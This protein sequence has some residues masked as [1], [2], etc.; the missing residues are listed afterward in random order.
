LDALATTKKCIHLYSLANL[1]SSE[2]NR[3]TASCT[4]AVVK[5]PGQSDDELSKLKEE[6]AQLRVGCKELTAQ[7]Q[8]NQDILHHCTYDLSTKDAEIED[9]RETMMYLNGRLDKM[10]PAASDSPCNAI[11]Y[12]P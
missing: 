5:T 6:N 3:N 7:S 11:V 4:T 2:V 1:F 12:L 10:T 8:L 9:L